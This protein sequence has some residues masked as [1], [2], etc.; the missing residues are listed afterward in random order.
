[1]AGVPKIRVEEFP[2]LV[3]DKKGAVKDL[4]DIVLE[5]A[6]DSADRLCVNFRINTVV[7]E[8]AGGRLFLLTDRMP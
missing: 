5:D 2:R 8:V 7:Q 6:L 1:M 4:S 3:L